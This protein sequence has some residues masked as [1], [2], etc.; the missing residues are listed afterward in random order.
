M[1]TMDEFVTK[2]EL[3]TLGYDPRTV[4]KHIEPDAMLISGA[5]QVELFPR[6]R[7]KKLAKALEEAT[8]KYSER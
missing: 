1:V 6:E 2:Q 3:R 8:A 7:V 5:R 4:R